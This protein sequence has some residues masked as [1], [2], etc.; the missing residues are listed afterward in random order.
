MS[1]L[2]AGNPD[3]EDEAQK[4][5]RLAARAARFNKSAPGRRNKDVSIDL[6]N[7]YFELSD[8]LIDVICSW[9]MRDPKK[10]KRLKRKG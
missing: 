9:K 6:P 3:G 8:D 10:G 5:T 4:A 2:E 7:S 1:A